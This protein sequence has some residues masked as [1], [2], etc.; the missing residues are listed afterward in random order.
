MKPIY[1]FYITFELLE[2]TVSE[3]KNTERFKENLP[4][5]NRQTLCVYILIILTF[6]GLSFLKYRLIW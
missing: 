6:R 1:N 2:K 3:K 5:F 4:V